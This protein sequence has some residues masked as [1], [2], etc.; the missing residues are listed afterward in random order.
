MMNSHEPGSGHLLEII[1]A[2]MSFESRRPS[3]KVEECVELAIA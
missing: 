2:R 1:E 3:C